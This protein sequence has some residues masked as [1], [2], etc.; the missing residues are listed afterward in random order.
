VNNQHEKW[1]R[2]ALKEA[3]RA[4]QEEEVPVGAVI[5]FENRVIGRGHNQVELLQDPTAHAEMIALTAA[6]NAL[7]KKWLNEAT[8]Y[9][10]IEPCAMCAG[11]MILARLKKLVYGAPEMKTGAHSR[12]EKKELTTETVNSEFLRLLRQIS[13]GLDFFV[14]FDQVEDPPIFLAGKKDIEVCIIKN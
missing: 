5:V 13:R 1:M 12:N 7:G 14:L 4:L 2:E 6:T 8:M 11:A 9:V 3:K 10:T